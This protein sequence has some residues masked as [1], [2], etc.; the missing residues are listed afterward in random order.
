MAP[1]TSNV[2]L[3]AKDKQIQPQIA[4][5]GHAIQPSAVNDLEFCHVSAVVMA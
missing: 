3:N 5:L 2:L 1:A 4:A